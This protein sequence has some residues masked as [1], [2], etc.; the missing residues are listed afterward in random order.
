MA[1]KAPPNSQ[2]LLEVVN[3]KHNVQQV[4]LVI[5][6]WGK[7]YT[8]NEV[9]AIIAG[10]LQYCV[11]NDMMVILGYCISYTHVCL[12]LDVP[13]RDLQNTLNNFYSSVRATLVQKE[14]VFIDEV[15]MEAD[16]EWQAAIDAS[17]QKLF[18]QSLRADE[19][20]VKL[21]TGKKVYL[22]YCDPALVR[23]EKKL[24]HYTWCSVIDYEGGKGPVKVRLM[25]K[26]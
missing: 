1:K 17:L 8:E 12:V 7:R 25:D 26:E 10:A 5:G 13:K 16:G 14:G 24:R 23:L 22:P 9:P 4:Q 15:M 2:F 21:I 3:V 20:L 19:Q 18:K 6:E 11:H